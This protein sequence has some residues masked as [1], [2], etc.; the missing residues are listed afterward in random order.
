MR[1]K[2][3]ARQAS[4]ADMTVREYAQ[5]LERNTEPGERLPEGVHEY[6]PKTNRWATVQQ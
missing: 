6:D 4:N 5:W 3:H 1:I 2:D